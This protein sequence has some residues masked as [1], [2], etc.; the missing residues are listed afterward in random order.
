M[1]SNEITYRSCWVAYFD[2]LGFRKRVEREQLGFVLHDYHK[3]LAAIKKEARRDVRTRWFSDTFL[4]YMSDDSEESFFAIDWACR[5]FFHNMVKERI[6]LRGSLTVGDLYVESDDVLIGPALVDAYDYAERQDWLG[7]V[8]TPNARER[9]KRSGT[10]G[11]DLYDVLVKPWYRDYDVP[12]KSS[13]RRA[14][15]RRT[16]NLPVCTMKPISFA[17]G[18]GFPDETKCALEALDDM[19]QGTIDESQGQ[20]QCERMNASTDDIEG[21]RRKYENTKRFLLDGVSDMSA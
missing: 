15:S 1:C 14:E 3:A 12:V 10:E 17:Y 11:K 13:R 2:L 20:P 8:L 6:P 5:F 19:E 21:V 9:L 18:V 7:F 16:E 4:F